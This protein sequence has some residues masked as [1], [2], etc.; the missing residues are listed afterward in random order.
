MTARRRSIFWLT[1]LF[2]LVLA[3]VADGAAARP[4]HRADG[5]VS[6]WVGDPTMLAGETRV[7]H[8]ELIYTDYIYDDYG[9][10]ID[11]ATKN[12]VFRSL[13]APTH[14]DYRYP[15]SANRY[16][17]NAADLRELRV[18][19][20]GTGLHLAAFL[21]TMKAADAA[22]VTVGIDSG[23]DV[24]EVTEWPRGAGIQTPG[25]DYFI[26]FWGTGGWIS[27]GRGRSRRLPR[28]QQAVSLDDNAIEVDVP[29][30]S[31]RDRLR[32]STVKLYVVT[33][34]ADAA[35]RRYTTVPAGDPTATTPGGGAPGSTAVFDVGFDANEVSTRVIGSHWAEQVQSTALAARDVSQMAQTVDLRSLER[36]FTDAYQPAAGRFYDRV[37][38]SGESYTGLGVLCS[39]SSDPC[40]NE[41]INLK[42]NPNEPGGNPTAQFLSPYQT[43]G[44]YI[45]A[46][47]QAGTPAKLLIN[48]HSLDV[49]HNE[50]AVVSPNLFS[51][52]GDQRSSFVIT[53]LARGLDTWY[54]NAGFQDVMEAWADLKANYSIDDGRTSIGGY[55][56]GGYMT[57]RMGLL[58]PDK[59]AA[60]VP[61]VGPPA[62]QLWAPPNPPTPAGEFQFVG[63]SNNIVYNALNLPY[64]INNSGADELVPVPGAEQQA[65]TFRDLAYTHLYY[66]YPTADH[67]ALILADQWAHS[68]DW[69][70]E[71]ARREENPIE[72]HYRR[73]PAM[74]LPQYGLRFDGAYWVDGMVLRGSDTCSPGAACEQSFGQV[75]AYNAGSGAASFSQA[76][77]VQFE[78]VGPP[79]AHVRGRTRVYGPR[80]APANRFDAIL[81][82]L[83]AV[84]FDAT[85]MNLNPNAEI[86]ARLTV[87]GNGAG[88]FEL[89]MRGNF[90]PVTASIR[91]IPSGPWVPVPV[92]QTPDGIVLNFAFS[93]QHDLK[94]TPQ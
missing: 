29:W 67:F 59:F 20:D 43:Y 73:Y 12:P 69:L 88:P 9:A 40:V 18:A 45:P 34:L 37:F 7:S 65:A 8:G 33:G 72:V 27:D 78:H 54:I 92:T 49:N 53:P 86:T 41:G 51:Q 17:Y 42:N 68:R 90:P 16:G 58:M 6:D 11:G 50:Y 76:Q 75:S 64:E 31:F 55:S 21:Q 81:W 2:L 83:Q 4:F 15:T 93:S 84:T 36:G 77:D 52:L 44:L 1:G 61:Y 87:G 56:M 19:A 14:G 13:L 23:R 3:L 28:Q 47:Y 25:V 46:G 70:D 60:A 57:Y 91:E 5:N 79:S 48:G 74:D 71:H 94:I 26:T 63:N 62:Y 35:A 39:L 85:K 82:D 80:G 38:R 66:F 24:G 89:T 10:D 22:V 32:G 30:R